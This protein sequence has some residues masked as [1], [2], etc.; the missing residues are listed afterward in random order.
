MCRNIFALQQTLTSSITGSREMALDTAKQVARGQLIM[1]SRKFDHSVMLKL[2]FSKCG[3]YW[4]QACSHVVGYIP[5]PLGLLCICY[6]PN[7]YW[8]GNFANCTWASKLPFY[9]HFC[10]W[11]QAPP[12]PLV[13]WRHLRMP[14]NKLQLNRHVMLLLWIHVK[15]ISV[16]M[17]PIT[18]IVL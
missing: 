9:L 2:P 14:L 1:T 10:T 16:S 3:P 15:N 7:T 13:A 18:W 5:G 6:S 17:E 12:P 4:T 8:N 11:C